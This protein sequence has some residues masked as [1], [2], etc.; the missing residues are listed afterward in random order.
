MISSEVQELIQ[1]CDRF[2]VLGKGRVQAILDR[3]EADE[4]SILKASSGT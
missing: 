3:R 1:I 2:V 4:V